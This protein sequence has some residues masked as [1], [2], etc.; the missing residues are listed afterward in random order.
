MTAKIYF[1]TDIMT[2]TGDYIITDTE[3]LAMDTQTFWEHYQFLSTNAAL[4][5]TVQSALKNLMS[6]CKPNLDSLLTQRTH[7]GEVLK[8][9]VQNVIEV[10]NTDAKLFGPEIPTLT[11]TPDWQA[12]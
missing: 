5:T 4:P 2:T 9:A 1:P 10:D 7:I 12:N 3:N 11:N 6:S 8:Q